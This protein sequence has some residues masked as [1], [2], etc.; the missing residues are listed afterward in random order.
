MDDASEFGTNVIP[1]RM[2]REELRDGYLRVLTE[3]YD[4]DRYFERTEALFLNSDFEIGSVRSEYWR[5]HPIRKL[6]FEGVRLVRTIFLYFRLLNAIP[7]KHLRQEYKRR[8]WRFLKVK[9][10]PGLA[11]FY[12]F[13]LAMHYHAYTMSRNMTSNRTAIVNSY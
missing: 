9:R 8:F 2:T 10:R 1:L 3:Q 11:L 4:P 13:H 5:K 6:K 7:E 12:L